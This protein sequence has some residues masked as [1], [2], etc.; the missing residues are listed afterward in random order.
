[1]KGLASF[2]VALA[3]A[4]GS[5]HADVPAPVR[6]ALSQAHV[7]L[8]AV[9]IRVERVEGGRATVSHRDQ[10]PMSPASVLKLVTSYA[11][12]D[13]LGPAYTFKT[14]VLVR[15]KLSA[16]VLE[17][18]LVLRGGGDP[19]LTYERLWQLV[20]NLRARGIREIGGDVILDRSFFAPAPFDPAGFDQ[21]PRRAYNVGA[22]ALLVNFGSVQFHFLP[23]GDAVRVVAE[24]D[25]PN[26]EIQSSIATTPEPCRSWR[27]ELTPEVTAHG[28]IATVVFTGRMPA[29]CGEKTWPLTVLEGAR[30]TESM[31]RW[32]WS[33]I[34]GVLRG[35][36]REGT[37]PADARLFLRQESE[38]LAE[39]VHA[40]NK[41]SN[42]VM[43]RHLFLALSARDGHAGELAASDRIAREWLAARGIDA[44]GAVLDNGSGLSREARLTAAQLAALLRSAWASPLMPEIVSSLPIYGVD[45]TLKE[46]RDRGA[47]GAAH[48]K[49]GTLNGVQSMAGYVDDTA[50]RRWIVVMMV[51]HPRAGDAQPA[52][53]ALVAWVREP[54]RP[55]DSR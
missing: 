8:D 54:G 4:C 19:K 39:L 27:R 46:R 51:N 44:R 31:F 43:A 2:V 16:G 25:L 14:D 34:G 45:G 15:G 7:P 30:F 26:I 37:A 20:Q 18:D 12:L 11:A 17:G 52:L 40:M 36:V 47:L 10:V 5:V 49:G 50:G 13:L 3:F 9:A 28:L 24:P 29:A 32:L 1:V 48:L 38:T 23:D 33:S 41:F 21:D 6:A 53:D 22:D 55:R 42:N 35:T